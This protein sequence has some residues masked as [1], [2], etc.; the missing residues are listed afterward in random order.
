MVIGNTM[1]GIIYREVMTT[2]PAVNFENLINAFC[3][4]PSYNTAGNNLH[5]LGPLLSNLTQIQE[6]RGYI[7]DKDHCVLQR[8]LPFTGKLLSGSEALGCDCNGKK[9]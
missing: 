2:K 5:Y 9:A 8:L 7:L 4:I 6:A 1:I 3:E